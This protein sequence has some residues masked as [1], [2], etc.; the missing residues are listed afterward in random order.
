[1]LEIFEIF[2]QLI[3]EGK[4]FFTKLCIFSLVFDVRW[5]AFEWCIC[6]QIKNIC[7]GGC[8]F[9]TLAGYELR[10]SFLKK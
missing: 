8:F 10:E 5:E 6:K 3:S 1:M 4:N 2:S 7:L 9:G